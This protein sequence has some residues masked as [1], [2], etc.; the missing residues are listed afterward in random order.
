MIL[1]CSKLITLRPRASLIDN[2]AVA[3]NNKGAI[4]AVGYAAN[5]IKRFSRHRIRRLHNAV[6]LPGLINLHSH[7]EL[8]PLLESVRAKTFPDWIINLIRAKKDLSKQNYRSATKININTL[9]HT[10]TTTVGEI[11]THGVSPALLKQA[12]LRAVVYHEIIS[13]D[14]VQGAHWEPPPGLP[15]RSSLL[16][17][18]GFSPH[19]PYT[20]SQAALRAI[21][22]LSKKKGIRV[23]MHIAESKEE[24][25]LLQRKKSGLEELYRFAGW[26]IGWA[27]QGD[28]SIEYLKGIG[29]LSP[30]LLAVHAVQVT[31]KDINWI[32]KSRVSIAH[33]PRSNK[34]TGVG[35]MQLKKFI[36]SDITVGLGTD[37]LAS[38]PTLNMW[39]EMRYAYHI[40]RQ[41]GVSAEDI[42]R[43]A[44][45][46]GAKALGLDKEIGTIEPGKKADMIAVPLPEKDTGDIYSDLLRETKSCSMS[47]VN[48][49]VLHN[50]VFNFR[51]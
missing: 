17:Q 48:G 7:I 47:M 22:R 41:S 49:K 40:H 27:P 18:V 16:I 26:D 13:M 14:P 15:S 28:S 35:K 8:P 23:A 5:I 4:L 20:V 42:F 11:C 6:L 10:G 39:D 2:G 51:C 21:S 45:I 3:I 32:R 33:C 24:I 25:R 1:T 31:G 37:S 43:F 29:F 46:N 34:E 9:I 38:S 19:T 30:N 44:T 50:K 36:D 12:G